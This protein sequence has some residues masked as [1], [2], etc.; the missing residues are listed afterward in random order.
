MKANYIFKK[1]IPFAL[2]LLMQF[3]FETYQNKY[4]DSISGIVYGEKNKPIAS[5]E[6][7]NLNNNFVAVSNKEGSFVIKGKIIWSIAIPMAVSNGL[8][9]WLGAKLAINK[10]NKF[11]RIFLPAIE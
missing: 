2:L 8:G 11:I 4:L 1:I 9:G 7:I 5:I 10:G 6:I 3:S